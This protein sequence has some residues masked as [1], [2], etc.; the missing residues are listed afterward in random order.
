MKKLLLPLI[1]TV[2]LYGCTPKGSADIDITSAEYETDNSAAYAETVQFNGFENS[3]FEKTIND[4]IAKDIN[5]ALISFDTMVSESADNIRMGNRCIL[6]IHQY[7]KN[8]KNDFISIIEEHYVYT[9]GAHG[10][11]SWYPRNIDTLANKTVLLS[12]LFEDDSY[13]GELNRQIDI[14][15]ED[16][17]DTYSDLWSHPKIT[18]EENFYINDGNLVIFYPPYELSYYARGFVEF[19][20]KLEDIEGYLKEEYKRLI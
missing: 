8:N 4:S 14:I 1:L 5:G 2:V 6:E 12:D 7:E 18:S 9:G 17:K 16:N 13:K 10:T 11:T 20:I 19:P 15:L 3:E